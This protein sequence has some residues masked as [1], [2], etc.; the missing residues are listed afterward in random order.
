VRATNSI[1]AFAALVLGCTAFGTPKLIDWTNSKT[2]D[3]DRMFLVERGE[4]ITFSVTVKGAKGFDWQINKSPRL[5]AVENGGKSSLTWQVPNEG[6]IWEIHVR[7]YGDGG[8]VHHEWVVSTLSVRE[9]PTFFDYF[10]DKRCWDRSET[11]PWGRPLP[12]WVVHPLFGIPDMS[13]CL[14]QPTDKS[15]LDDERNTIVELYYPYKHA[16]GTWKFR[17]CVPEGPHCTHGGWTHFRFNFLHYPGCGHYQ[18]MFYVREAGQDHAYFGPGAHA[19]DH[20]MGVGYERNSN[21]WYEVVIVH[22]PDDEFYAFRDGILEMR[23]HDRRGSRCT[24]MSIRLHTY[25]PEH[26]PNSKIYID[27]IEVYKDKFLFPSGYQG[28]A[29]S[30]ARPFPTGPRPRSTPKRN[31]TVAKIPLPPDRRISDWW[32]SKTRD[33]D[34][35]F[36]VA[37]KERITFRI[38]AEG[39]DRFRWLVNKHQVAE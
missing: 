11:D 30:G 9:A 10:S 7:A 18:R 34:R 31:K 6:G 27:C 29:I 33:R 1:A 24:G 26:T 36:V 23:G 19:W 2:A 25:T 13:R 15:I 37:S 14:L 17:Y 3:R 16:Y 20:D 35:M 39:C 38:R 22:T 5:G 28:Q 4:R 12:E 32:N 21:V 8:D